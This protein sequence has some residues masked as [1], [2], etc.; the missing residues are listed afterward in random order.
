MKKGRNC[1]NKYFISFQ[2]PKLYSAVL[3][4]GYI[5]QPS[6]TLIML[7]VTVSLQTFLRIRNVSRKYIHKQ[8]AKMRT[9]K[10][11]IPPTL[12]LSVQIIP[13]YPILPYS[14]SSLSCQSFTSF[15]HTY[16]GIPSGRPTPKHRWRSWKQS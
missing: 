11:K 4:V 7:C 8:E 10:R 13:F 14:P 6:S 16:S 5:H 9:P 15:Q 12:S 1:F 3:Y 2:K